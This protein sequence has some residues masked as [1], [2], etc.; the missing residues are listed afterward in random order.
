MTRLT[1]TLAALATLLVATPA[2]ASDFVYPE[3]GKIVAITGDTK[4]P[5][6]E[7]SGAK[8][9]VVGSPGAGKITYASGSLVIVKHALGYESHLSGIASPRGV[10]TVVKAGEKVA[11]QGARLHFELRRYGMKKF[12]PGKVG[13]SLKLGQPILWSYRG[14]SSPAN[15]AL[16]KPTSASTIW[17]PSYDAAKATDGLVTTGWSPSGTDGAP[18][19]QVD[20]GA[21]ALIEKIELVTRQELDQPATRHNFAIWAS[22]DADMSKSHVVL[23]TQDSSTL[24][25]KSTFSATIMRSTAYRYVAAVKTTSEYFYVTELRVKG[26]FSGSPVPG[27][28]P[29]PSVP[30]LWGG[31]GVWVWHPDA[32]APSVHGAAAKKAGFLWV[33]VQIH[34]GLTTIKETEDAF[35]AGW[36]GALRS[37]GF[38]VGGWAPV[39]TSP[40]EEAALGASLVKKWGLDFYIADAEAEYKYTA[41]DGSWD[42]VA[43][44]RSDKFVKAF[45]VAAP[46]LPAAV[47]SYGRA[48]LADLDWKAWRTGSFVYMPQAYWNEYDIYEPTLC[49]DAAVKL[50]WSKSEV[51]PTIGIWGGGA[52]KYVSA[53]EY[54]ADMLTAKVVGF[55]LYL[56]ESM[57]TEEW[58]V[59]GAGITAGLA[60]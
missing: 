53:A 9:R 55:S 22:N 6:L 18:W 17:S 51:F 37:M 60:R 10:G 42:P 21:P 34:D 30:K 36:I 52:R 25:F 46:D 40:E 56:G 44:A 11:V 59:L 24:P 3:T 16:G 2:L 4:T 15:L 29:P 33:T 13:E 8:G 45:R 5:T 50:G 39:R 28:P 41:P 47:S 57:P 49:M 1:G 32:F 20:L 31:A 43:Y 7:I 14:L 35:A 58:P 19:I 48:D 38:L 54:V 12:M 23:A 27:T 26:A